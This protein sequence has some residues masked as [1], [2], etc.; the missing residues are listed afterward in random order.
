MIQSLSPGVL[1]MRSA[2][3]GVLYFGIVFA[4][5]FVLGT[6]RTLFLVP[7]LGEVAAVSIEAPVILGVSW[8]VAGFCIRRLGVPSDLT[9]RLFMGGVA[10]ALLMLAEAGVSTEIFGNSL[11]GFLA[12]LTSIPGIM[13]FA[14][15]IA[16]ALFPALRKDRFT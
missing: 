14:S 11:L 2:A 10:F 16:F 6:I 9:S 12:S 15:Q 3:A 8:A 4:A 13:G 1:S 5:G 7:R